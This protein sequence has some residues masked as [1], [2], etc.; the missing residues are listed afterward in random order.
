VMK[1]GIDSKRLETTIVI[2]RI[3]VELIATKSLN[4]VWEHFLAHEL[5]E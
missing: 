1:T 2:D 3:Q 5:S 4:G